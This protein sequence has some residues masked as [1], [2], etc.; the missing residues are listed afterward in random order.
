M[1]STSFARA[2]K[3]R[4]Y[5]LQLRRFTNLC[6]RHVWIRA[7]HADCLSKV[8]P[9]RIIQ[10]LCGCDVADAL[11]EG[12]LLLKRVGKGIVPPGFPLVPTDLSTYAGRSLYIVLAS[13]VCS[14]IVTPA[15]TKGAPCVS[16]AAAEVIFAP[17]SS[18][19]NRCKT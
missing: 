12:E 5:T 18:S 14:R 19:V 11:S 3:A 10:L 7:I 6:P 17:Q 8:T 9:T 16:D 2:A 13:Y 1:D 4:T 15:A